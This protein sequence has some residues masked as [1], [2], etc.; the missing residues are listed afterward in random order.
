MHSEKGTKLLKS[1]Y[2]LPIHTR[3]DTPNQK[4]TMIM[5]HEPEL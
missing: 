1:I 5:C 3:R 4:A 2:N